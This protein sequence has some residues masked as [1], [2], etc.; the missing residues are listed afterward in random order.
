[1][2]NLNKAELKSVIGGANG[3]GGAGSAP[4]WE[5]G[6]CFREGAGGSFYEA[7]LTTPNGHVVSQT[8]AVGT[9]PLHDIDCRGGGVPL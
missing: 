4:Q 5:L 7:T 1:M 2:N 9:G 8:F 6:R 3:T